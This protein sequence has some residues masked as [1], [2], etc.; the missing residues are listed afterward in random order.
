M[1]LPTRL[2]LLGAAGLAVLAP[3]AILFPELAGALVAADALWVAALLAD[4]IRAARVPFRAFAPSR[5]PPPAFSVHRP[6]PVE[7]RWPNPLE[8]PVRLV[9]REGLPPPVAWTEG[10]ERVITLAPLR[11]TLE[12]VTVVPVRRGKGGGGPIHVRMRG[13]WG[14]VWR[15]RVFPAPWPITVFPR[16]DKAL[17]SLTPTARRR[18]EAGLRRLRR[19]GEGRLFE[20][21]REWVPDDDTRTIDWKATARRGKTIV[22]QYEDERR[23][24]VMIVL[25]AGR[26]LTAETEG[27]PRLESAI[28][29]A[30][31]LAAS[32]VDHDD[33]V[34]LMVFTDRVE[35][36]LR[37]TRGRRGLRA[38]MD[39]LAGVEGRL[40]EPDYPGAFAQLAARSRKRAFTVVFTDL[41]DRTASEA[42]VAQIGTLRPRHLPLAVTLRDPA[43][44]RLATERPADV[45]GA[46]R[47]AAAEELLVARAEALGEMRSRG[48]LVLDVPAA[49]AA[50]SVV[51]QYE[52]L[53]RGGRI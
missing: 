18:R 34:G 37:P 39:A 10:D 52:R 14:L 43:L 4:G 48:V 7:Y 53:K 32:A 51:T 44:E 27:R 36:F 21:L 17:P 35:N 11:E 20:S 31:A 15:Q 13:P 46:F 40:T 23:Q 47:R 5:R 28:D 3:G 1:I 26:M 30:L 50:H 41:I 33:D 45:E 19:P 2:W 8:R 29:A 25:D 49:D 16:L 6:L 9:V 42:M 24:Q 38:V 22:R 12:E